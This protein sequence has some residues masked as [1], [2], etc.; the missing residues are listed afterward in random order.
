MN[1]KAENKKI[2]EIF[3]EFGEAYFRNVEKS[4]IKELSVLNSQVISTGGGV[5]LNPEN[6]ENLKCNSRIYFLDRPLDMLI[7]TSDRPL[8]S[9]RSDLEKRYKERYELYKSSADVIIDG[10]KTVEEVAK[11]IEEDFYEYSC[12]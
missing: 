7:T 10:S 12:N 11:I 2:P 8:S 6:I 5:V 3:E 4:I 1:D 9:N